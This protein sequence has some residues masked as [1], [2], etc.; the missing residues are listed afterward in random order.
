[1]DFGY[2]FYG[3]ELYFIY[4]S[5]THWENYTNHKYTKWTYLFNCEP[6]QRKGISEIL[7]V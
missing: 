1:M 4:Q 6:G 5:I 7:K 2:G 3:S